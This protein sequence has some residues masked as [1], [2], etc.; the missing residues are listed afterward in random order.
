MIQ[1][2]TLEAIYNLDAI[3]TQ[4]PDIDA[5]WLGT[6]DA[7]IS[8]DLPG[9]GG[10]GGTEPEWVDAVAT[11][12]RVMAKHGIAK[13]GFAMGPPEVM[14]KMASDKSFIVVAADVVALAGLVGELGTARSIFPAT[15]KEEKSA[16]KVEMNGDG[17]GAAKV[18][19]ET[20]FPIGEIL[21]NGNSQA[22]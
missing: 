9:N 3:L 14:Q 10:M 11:Y 22:K 13:A 21:V 2:E 8:M 17:E 6:L 5:V 15:V 4:V 20:G 18:N 12:E 1:I 7:R 19:D 16:A